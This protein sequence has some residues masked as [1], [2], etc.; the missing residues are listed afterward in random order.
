MRNLALAWT[1][2]AALMAAF[3]RPASAQEDLG[4]FL[5]G[6]AI[7]FGVHEGAHIVADLSFGVPPRVERTTSGPVPFFAIVHDPVTPP[8][9]FV[10][11]SAG[12]WSQHLTSEIILTR[13]PELRR[14]HAPILKGMLAFNVLASA[15]YAVAAFAGIGPDERDTRGMAVSSRTP[16]PVIGALVL[17]PAVLDAMRYYWP[18]MVW[19]RWASRGAKVG[20]VLLIVRAA[21]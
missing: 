15:T 1:L 18:Q 19:L 21:Q 20:G 12:F 14:Q 9:E 6:A 2:M 11:S 17:A 16:E 8:R 13:H 7:A 4:P 5:A 3:P 10:I